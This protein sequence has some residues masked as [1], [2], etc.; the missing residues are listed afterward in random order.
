MLRVYSD[1]PIRRSRSRFFFFRLHTPELK[2][3]FVL[4]KLDLKILKLVKSSDIV[5]ED[6]VNKRECIALK[7]IDCL[8]SHLIALHCLSKEV[9]THR[10]AL[11]CGEFRTF[12][13]F[14]SRNLFHVLLLVWVL[15]LHL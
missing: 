9:L 4:T 14:L 3:V 13:V 2:K 6:E 5:L 11:V 15:V 1:L 10:K 12:L 8:A 7:T